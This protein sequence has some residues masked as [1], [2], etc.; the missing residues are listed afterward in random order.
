VLGRLQRHPFAV[1]AFFRRSLV[2]SYA[3]PREALAP[4]LDPGLELDTYD[5]WG[6]L[7]IALVQTEA[8]RPRGFPKWL[9]RDFF[10][11]GYRI[12]TR[13]R[14][15]GQP[16]LRGLR[17]LRSDTDRKLMASLGNVFTHYKYR[18]AKVTVAAAPERLEIAISTPNR[19]ADLHVIADLSSDPSVLPDGSPFR[20]MEDARAFAGPLP[21]TFSYDTSQKKMVVVKGVRKTWDPRPVRANVRTVTYLEQPRFAQ[22][23]PRLA[24]A[25]YLESVPYSWNRATLE[26]VLE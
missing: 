13:L 24:N 23:G 25:F 16:T 5:Q 3:M 7:A 14:R 20:S 15:R 18:L 21:F 22:A 11:S 12:F 6:F 2:L 10:L 9:G 1:Q 19:E 17:I 4:L 26:D 8:L